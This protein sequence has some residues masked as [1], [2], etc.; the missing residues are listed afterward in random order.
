MSMDTTNN[1]VH[2][3]FPND[4]SH[5]EVTTF[6]FEDFKMTNVFDDE[7]FG[8]WGNTHVA[9]YRT[10]YERLKT[11]SQTINLKLNTIEVKGGIRLK[12]TV[13]NVFY[14]G[15]F[16]KIR[17]YLIWLFKKKNMTFGEYLDSPV[18]YVME[19]PSQIDAYHHIDA[20]KELEELVK[21]ELNNER[22]G[23]N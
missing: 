20:E 18:N 22:K 15:F 7:V 1:I 21:Q 8:W 14:V 16:G 4:S 6:K 19:P 10:D 9:I 2:V 5:I 23:N 13:R 12:L 11:E 17:T 3:R